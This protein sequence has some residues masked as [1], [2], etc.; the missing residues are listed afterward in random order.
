M[1]EVRWKR[2][3]DWAGGT[4]VSGP[5]P[6]SPP[7][8]T[9]PPPG[10]P[11]PGTPP[12]SG[13]PV[14]AP[15]QS[16]TIREDAAIGFKLAA[17]QASNSPTSW[18]IVSGDPTAHWTIDTFGRLTLMKQLNATTQGSYVPQVLA[19]NS[20]GASTPTYVVIN[21]T[22]A[23]APPPAPGG[24]GQTGG[25]PNSI[26]NL[27]SAPAANQ[28]TTGISSREDWNNP[29]YESRVL[30]GPVVGESNSWAVYAG[31]WDYEYIVSPTQAIGP[32]QF[33]QRVGVGPA[34]NQDCVTCEVHQKVPGGTKPA[35]AISE[36]MSYPTILMGEIMSW[37]GVQI[38]RPANVPQQLQNISALW[39]GAKSISFSGT[40]GK[41]HLAHDM[42]IG[43][44]ADDSPNYSTA[45]AQTT[46]EFMIVHRVFQSYGLGPGHRP[47]GS[48][49]GT[50]TI[51][52]IQWYIHTQQGATAYDPSG[53]NNATLL[54][55]IPTSGSL[56]DQFNAKY[57]F[58]FCRTTRWIDLPN[59][60]GN[61]FERGANQ[62]DVMIKPWSYVKHDSFG[63]E[64]DATVAGEA[65]I[66]LNSAFYRMNLD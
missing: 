62:N 34:T 35:G 31:S 54:A 10:T 37:A 65:H 63:V 26:L 46:M 32:G 51:G 40:T 47:S 55:F 58:D 5:A 50:L 33:H 27:A 56:P 4:P 64:L 45:V 17:I 30:S 15:V 9:T 43:N 39:L 28:F 18:V 61:R 49:R 29:P 11:P 60:P 12:P 41:G 22:V 3:I 57:L 25:V 1:A 23:P 16:F 38:R 19:Y 42:R 7:A 2:G 14:I 66:I 21:V 6:G 52:G 59:G 36:V 13:V 48:H 44:T 53:L 8:P 24:G 20:L